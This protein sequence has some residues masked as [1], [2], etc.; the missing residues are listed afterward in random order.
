MVV[1]V[2][3]ARMLVSDQSL[4]VC[5]ISKESEGVRENHLMICHIQTDIQTD[6]KTYRQTYIQRQTDRHTDRQTY[7]HTDRQAGRQADRQTDILN[8]NYSIDCSSIGFL[9]YVHMH[10]SQT[11]FMSIAE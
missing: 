7:R 6:R 4:Q 2:G 11:N 10:S 9:Y 3:M 5:Q 1:S 8:Q